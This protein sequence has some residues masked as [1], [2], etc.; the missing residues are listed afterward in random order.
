MATL[1][2]RIAALEGG[3]AG[4]DDALRPTTIFLVGRGQAFDEVSYGDQTWHRQ[5]GESEQDLRER[6]AREVK[7]DRPG[8]ILIL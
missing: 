7:R 5:P 1:E 8:Q 2:T 3:P 6:V 4:A